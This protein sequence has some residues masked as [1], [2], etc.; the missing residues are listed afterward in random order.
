MID[1]RIEFEGGALRYREAGAVTAPAVVLLHQL[2][3]DSRDWDEVAGALADR[4][5]VLA[6]DLRGHGESPRTPPFTFEQMR[7]DV[8]RFVDALHLE[9]FSLIGHSMGGTV[10]FLLAQAWPDRVDTLIVEDT[11][12]PTGANLPEPPAELPAAVPFEWALVRTIVRQLNAPDPS[13]WNRLPDIRARTLIVGGGATS[14]IPQDRL[15][16]VAA[17]IPNARLVTIDGAGHLVH[18]TKPD[19]FIPLVRDFLLQQQERR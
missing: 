9:R 6:L 15:K 5:R 8:V 3:R 11:P 16:D 12:P 10:A 1:R 17:L 2:G 19:A 7:D 13:W 18:A 14:P 4:F